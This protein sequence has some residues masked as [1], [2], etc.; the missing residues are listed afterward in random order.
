MNYTNSSSC[1]ST[2]KSTSAIR[3]NICKMR[4]LLNQAESF[5]TYLE[6]ESN[7]DAGKL[8]HQILMKLDDLSKDTRSLNKEKRAVI[9]RE[10]ASARAATTANPSV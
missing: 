5:A 1:Q 10:R 3:C 4:S 9:E 8:L 7:D 2:A 6:D